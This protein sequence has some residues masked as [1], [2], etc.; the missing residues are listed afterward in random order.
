MSTQTN[1]QSSKAF[2]L[3][4]V[5]FSNIQDACAA[6]ALSVRELVQA[7]LERIEVESPHRVIQAKC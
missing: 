2:T 6:R 3:L 7:Y 5:T 4:E 1:T